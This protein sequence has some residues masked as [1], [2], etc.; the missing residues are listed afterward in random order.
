[1]KS[2]IRQILLLAIFWFLCTVFVFFVPRGAGT[3]KSET[4][5]N[6]KQNTQDQNSDFS[7]WSREQQKGT[8]EFWLLTHPQVSTEL[9]S[10]F[11]NDFF[12]KRGIRV[13]FKEIS[14][15]SGNELSGDL[16]LLPYDLL[17]DSP[18][19]SIEFQEDIRSL[20]IP[21]LGAFLGQHSDFLPFALDPAIMYGLSGLQG[22]IDGLYAAFQNFNPKTAASA[23]SFW[24][25]EPRKD[26]GIEPTQL[27]SNLLFAQQLEDFIRFND[28]GAFQ[29]WLAMNNLTS[30]QQHKLRNFIFISTLPLTPIRK[31]FLEID[32][33][34]FSSFWK[35]E[36]NDFI[37][38]QWYPYQYV[39]LPS[40]LY[41]FAI[42]ASGGQRELVNQFLLDY[43]DRAFASWENALAMKA[44]M[45]PV[46]QNEFQANCWTS[47]CDLP[48]EIVVI[49][50]GTE[51]I[52]RFLQDKL[53]WKVIEKKVQPD[54]Y[55]REASL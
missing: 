40:R 42:P 32:F 36:S 3:S 35:L 37:T 4:I 10:G 55:F 9:L 6:T 28:V 13:R 27:A 17:A 51:K 43:M 2:Q 46:F 1:M 26:S 21:Q 52:Q 44:K 47:A 49:E 15:L 24:L 29:Q 30:E 54:L 41:G 7:S 8:G 20:F 14:L 50:K 16:A 5:N 45:L 23:F 18:I 31:G 39:G 53:L 22:G 19:K 38:V 34:F 25:Y 12:E 48:A 11:T 33:D